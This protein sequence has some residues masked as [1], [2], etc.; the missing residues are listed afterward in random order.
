MVKKI[1]KL[2]LQ[3]R[4]V[5]FITVQSPRELKGAETLGFVLFTPDGTRSKTP[6]SETLLTVLTYNRVPNMH[7]NLLFLCYLRFIHEFWSSSTTFIAIRLPHLY[8]LNNVN[9]SRL[10]INVVTKLILTFLFFL[11]WILQGGRN[12]HIYDKD[13]G[14]RKR[15]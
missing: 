1:S 11:S 13:K 4:T 2:G 9:S 12:E 5:L 10:T 8:L 3:Q 7:C 14:V 15:G 6:F